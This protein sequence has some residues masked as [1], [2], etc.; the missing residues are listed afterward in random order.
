MIKLKN[1]HTCSCGKVHAEIPDVPLFVDKESPDFTVYC[2]P[3]S[4]CKSHQTT[5]PDNVQELPES[6]A[7]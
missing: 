1:P 5:Y 7:A 3:C 4:F 6:D 2:W